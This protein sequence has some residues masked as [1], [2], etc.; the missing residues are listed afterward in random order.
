VEN[1]PHD[2]LS[3]GSAKKVSYFF[4]NAYII[5]SSLNLSRKVSV[6]SKEERGGEGRKRKSFSRKEGARG[7]KAK[8]EMV[9]SGVR[10]GLGNEISP[11]SLSRKPLHAST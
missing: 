5:S 4:T 3:V 2:A 7:W 6:I 10:V 9:P 1:I 8:R 11:A